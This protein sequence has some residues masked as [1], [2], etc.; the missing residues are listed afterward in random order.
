MS[1][2]LN[3]DLEQR[4]VLK[5]QSGQY[6]SVDEVVEKGLDL[7]EARDSSEAQHAGGDARPIWE[8]IAELGRSVPGEEW[9]K[10]PSDLSI[11]LDHYLY[12][13]PKRSE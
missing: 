12:G 5:V 9:A 2:V 3:P 13:A 1:I 4:I 8:T 10:V 7:L 6:H 11:N